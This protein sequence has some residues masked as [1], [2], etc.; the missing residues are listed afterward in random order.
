MKSR[1][2]IGLLVLTLFTL[3]F[4][5]AWHFLVNRIEHI[6][7]DNHHSITAK[8]LRPDVLLKFTP[9]ESAR[10]A[11]EHSREFMYKGMMY[12]IICSE[13]VNDTIWYWC[14]LD[15]KESRLKK[16]LNH[17]LAHGMNSLPV[18]KDHNNQLTHFF[19]TL[20]FYSRDYINN[21]QANSCRHIVFAFPNQA[22]S[23]LG[24]SPPSPPPKVA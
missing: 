14:H 21:E 8:S 23:T 12:D 16:E 1:Q 19:K 24:I 18:Q 4:F 3:P 22:Y 20:F 13:F 9:E 11:W 10:L 2:L 15:I 17:L 5:G 6:K 7:K